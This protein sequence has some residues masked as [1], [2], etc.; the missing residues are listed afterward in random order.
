MCNFY[1]VL[2]VST[3][4]DAAALR[5][6]Y[7]RR[8]EQLHPDR[9]VLTR[10]PARCQATD[11]FKQLQWAY[12]VLSNPRWRAIYD[13]QPEIF[14]EYRSLGLE[15][16]RAASSTIVT[17]ES[18]GRESVRSSIV[19]QVSIAVR[20][21]RLH[22]TR[23]GHRILGLSVLAWSCLAGLTAILVVGSFGWSTVHREVVSRWLSPTSPLLSSRLVKS[24]RPSPPSSE[25]ELCHL[26][27]AI[28]RPSQATEAV[29]ASEPIVDA[30]NQSAVQPLNNGGNMDSGGDVDNAGV[31]Q[32]L[33]SVSRRR[34]G[35]GNRTILKMLVRK[36]V[37]SDRFNSSVG[38]GV[39]WRLHGDQNIRDVEPLPIPWERVAVP[40]V[41]PP[42]RDVPTLETQF[43]TLEP[44]LESL[45]AEKL[46]P[47]PP[48]HE[49][50]RDKVDAYSSPGSRVARQALGMKR[51]S[52][53]NVDKWHSGPTTTPSSLPR[54]GW[55]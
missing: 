13:R 19:D 38:A 27:T 48:P 51:P 3:N 24:G 6:A 53:R 8:A 45:R 25:S 5:A 14:R 49:M 41:Q 34:T 55:K 7:L 47:I 42:E 46:R 50:R 17:R 31:I 35:S 9:Q 20:V 22:S 26:S 54:L 30:T 16:C 52:E 33:A 4:A 15:E 39:D 1:E 21:G 37:A 28:N 12:E 36:E 43:A 44:A 32:D 29:A 18:V 23:R 10:L 40:M 2:Q 11:G